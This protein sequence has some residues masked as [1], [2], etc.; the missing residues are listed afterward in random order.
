MHSVLAFKDQNSTLFGD[1]QRGR[2]GGGWIWHNFVHMFLHYWKKAPQGHFLTQK[3]WTCQI[4]AESEQLGKLLRNSHLGLAWT[5]LLNFAGAFSGISLDLLF[6]VHQQ[7]QWNTE[8]VSVL[9][10]CIW[11][12][13]NFKW[14]PIDTYPGCQRFLALG[15]QQLWLWPREA[16]SLAPSLS[17]PQLLAAESEEPLAPRV[18]DT[19]AMMVIN[20]FLSPS[21]SIFHQKNLHNTV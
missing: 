6:L 4:S 19:R 15:S 21:H 9:S 13:I 2:G 20:I 17:Q 8:E 3:E 5:E 1:E 14:G 18:I 10:D 12:L 7:A 16:G 11:P